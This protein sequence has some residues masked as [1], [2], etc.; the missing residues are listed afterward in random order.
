MLFVSCTIQATWILSIELWREQF[1]FKAA[2]T[3][4]Q[5]NI[6]H[7]T[8]VIK[9]HAGT[10]KSSNVG[11]H[12]NCSRQDAVGKA[13]VHCRM[14]AQQPENNI[15]VV[16]KLQHTTIA[17]STKHVIFPIPY[18][19]LRYLCF[20]FKLYRQWSNLWLS[21]F[22]AILQITPK[23][24]ITRKKAITLFLSMSLGNPFNETRFKIH[25]PLRVLK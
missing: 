6:L 2:V 10:L 22:S 24:R 20:G 18:C 17:Q 14:L 15:N 8:S 16:N 23:G 12:L 21:C 1:F 4:H 3:Y 11:F 5:V 19:S 13:I 9:L 7:Y 25:A